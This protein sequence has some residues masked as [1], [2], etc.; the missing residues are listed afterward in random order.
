[1]SIFSEILTAI[2][3]YTISRLRIDESAKLNKDY[4]TNKVFFYDN[5]FLFNDT[6]VGSHSQT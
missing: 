5:K 3:H 2:Y 6:R 4:A 1:M